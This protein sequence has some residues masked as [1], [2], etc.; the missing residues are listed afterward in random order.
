MTPAFRRFAP[1]RLGVVSS[2]PV[3]LGCGALAAIVIACAALFIAVHGYSALPFWDQW[4]F[5]SPAAIRDRF[6]VQHNE[7]RILL[8]RLIILLDQTV[9]GGSSL[10]NLFIIYLAQALHAVMLVVLAWRAGLRSLPEIGPAALVVLGTLF[11]THQFE[12]FV[13]GFQTQFVIVYAAATGAFLSLARY[14]ETKRPHALALTILGVVIP[15]SEMANGVLVGLIAV[16]MAMV[17]RLSWRVIA[18]LALVAALVFAL[19]VVHY[20]PVAHHSS[21]AQ[22]LTQPLQ[23]VGYVLAYTG[24]MMAG[25]LTAGPLEFVGSHVA[26]V[27]LAMVCGGVICLMNAAI[28]TRVLRKGAAIQPAI[29]ALLAVNLFILATATITGLGRMSFGLEQALASRYTSG[30][31]IM[32]AVTFILVLALLAPLRP[33]Q[34]KTPIAA[35]TCAV[36]LVLL[37]FAQPRFIRA[38][39][40]RRINADE[41]T[42]ALLTGVMQEDI[43]RATFP[44]LSDIVRGTSYLKSENLSIYAEPWSAWLGRKLTEFSAL[45]SSVCRGWINA[46]E[47]T[48][49]AVAVRVSGAVGASPLVIR[50]RVVLIDAHD[51][52]V[53]YGFVHTR[54]DLIKAYRPVR[55]PIMDAAWL[56]YAKADYAAPLRAVLM[57]RGDRLICRIGSD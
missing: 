54:F 33:E 4:E 31:A 27:K 37:M 10:L 50:P 19:Y 5:I 48:S 36:L 15:A 30:G 26:E 14:A 3:L 42:A 7:H 28:V 41:V 18:L 34:R 1:L 51:D 12:N 11:S 43:L 57:D 52:V 2:V 6:F 25:T 39:E 9:F 35:A 23:L 47:P 29:C 56:G 17:L 24:G 13:W 44:R 40:M 22:S 32:I 38:A 46:P 45:P 53:G 55:R 49:T 20:S 21:I 8:T 16:A